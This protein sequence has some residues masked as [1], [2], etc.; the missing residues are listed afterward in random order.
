MSGIDALIKTVAALREPE[1]GCPWDIEQDHQS[2]AECLI[3]EC[4]ELL[5]TIDRL[6]MDHMEEELGDVLLQVVMHAQMAQEAGQFDFDKVCHVVNDKLVHRHPHVFGD[7]ALG[8]SDAVLKQWDAIKAEEKKRGPEQ[9]GRFKDL[10]RQLPA[11]MF[12][13]DVY[14]QIK[15]QGMDAAEVIDEGGIEMTAAALAADEVALGKQ[16][17]EIAAACRIK[18]LDA[19]SALRRYAQSVV[20][21]LDSK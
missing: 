12:A 1:T 2:I 8:D 19:E 20:D 3:D 10:P 4:C 9:K 18:K 15:K 7:G 13:Q 11:L 21:Q 5:Q 14:K 16:L 6:D 17:F